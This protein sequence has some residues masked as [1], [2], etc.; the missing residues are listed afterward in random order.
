[1]KNHLKN[2]DFWGIIEE[3]VFF[4]TFN[5]EFIRVFMRWLKISLKVIIV[6]F[7]I[8]GF[9]LTAS[10]AALQLGFT[11]EEG[12]VDSNNRYFEDIKDKYNQSFKT[13][14]TSF[15]KKDY[16]ALNRILI[17]NKFWPENAA[18]I[19]NAYSKGGDEKEVLRMIDA[20]ELHLQNNSLYLNEVAKYEREK[21]K[22]TTDTNKG[23][24]FEWM[25]ISEWTDFK[26]AVAKD[27]ILI[28]SVAKLTGV[29]PRLIVS[30]LVGEQ[31]R[32]FNSK[33]EAYKKWI[34]PL[35]ILSVETKF[36][37]GVTGIKELTARRIEH[38][39]KDS[40]SIYY[41]GKKYEKLLDFSTDSIDRE[42]FQRL[43]SYKSHYYSY[44]YAALFIKQ[45]K[46]QWEKA[47]FPITERPEILATLFNVGYEQ[48]KPKSNPRVGGSSIKI[49][50]KIYS[51]GSI[52]YEFYY[53]GELYDLFPFKSKK[54]DWDEK[55]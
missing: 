30:V 38:H 23:S 1:M 55:M 4:N 51:F 22:V 18:L 32:L 47:G 25:N 9:F 19:L 36:S 13:D 43:T 12:A 16:R 54:F 27:K 37:L 41:L 7:A 26:F 40:T 3:N 11:K 53:S 50:D 24:I 14:T 33:R 15:T 42:R 29:E 10:Y 44:M 39:I 45:M 28:D 48:S 49:N 46:V 31:I 17:L 5:P 34:G 2:I 8:A 6:L 20:A 52:A 21:G 35:K